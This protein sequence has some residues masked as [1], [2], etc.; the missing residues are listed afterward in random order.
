MLIADMHGQMSIHANSRRELT[1]FRGTIDFLKLPF[2]EAIKVFE[3]KKIV[4]PSAF[5]KLSDGYK[6]RSFSVAKLT[7]TYTT[8]HV[9]GIL[10]RALKDGMSREDFVKNIRAHL[11]ALGMDPG[12]KHYWETVYSTNILG[13]A[14]HGRWVQMRSPEVLAER[15][16]WRYVTAGDA[17]VRES[18][19]AMA[20]KIFAH[21]DPVWDTWFPPNGY[22]CRC[23]VVSQTISETKNRGGASQA[24]DNVEPD[25]GFRTSPRGWLR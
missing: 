21:D 7:Q 25:E 22:R 6:Q 10:D 12:S 8:D 13:S 4:S 18:H 19:R 15:P 23:S 5:K 20:G 11:S 9:K 2:K 3:S 1:V 24:P 16:Y 14:A 17:N